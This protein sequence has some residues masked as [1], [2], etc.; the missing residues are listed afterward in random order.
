MLV[1]LAVIVSSQ[2]SLPQAVLR[3]DA[4]LKSQPVRAWNY[5]VQDLSEGWGAQCSFAL[6]GGGNQRFYFQRGTERIEFKQSKG[7]S[8][9]LLHDQ[10]RYE[11]YVAPA[12]WTY[13]PTRFIGGTMLAIPPFAYSESVSEIASGGKWEQ[14][15]RETIKGVACDKLTV[16]V[17]GGRAIGIHT[18]W[19]DDLGQIV[20]WHRKWSELSAPREVVFE[21]DFNIQP[22]KAVFDTDLPLGYVPARLPLPAT[23]TVQASEEAPLGDWL[24]ARTGRKVSIK[25]QMAGEPIVIVFTDPD[26]EVSQKIEPFLVTLRKRLKPQRCALAEVVLTKNAPNTAVSDKDRHV[27]WDKDGT[28]EEDWGIPGT[29]YFVMINRSGMFVAGWQG[30]RKSDEAKIIENFLE[31]LKSR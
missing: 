9:V 24:E 11:E 31:A 20:R 6:A 29:P 3:A 25:S 14:K 19:I 18:A 4:R 17:R 8:V 28:I 12:D 5:S 1:A 30:Y 26:C 15:G 27:Y 2:S 21:F 13:P 22:V 23:R 10:A 16:E 7:R